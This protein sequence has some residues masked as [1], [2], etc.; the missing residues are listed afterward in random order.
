[1]DESL[2]VSDLVISARLTRKDTKRHLDEMKSL[3]L[4]RTIR[5]K[6]ERYLITD[7]GIKWL[8]TYKGMKGNRARKRRDAPDF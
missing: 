1:M 8:E 3:G 6:F 2:T 4:V 5:D 7:E